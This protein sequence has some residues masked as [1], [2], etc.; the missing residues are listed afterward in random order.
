M[1]ILRY[2][3]KEFLRQYHGKNLEEFKKF[4]NENDYKIEYSHADVDNIYNKEGDLV[5]KV[6]GEPT[7]FLVTIFSFSKM[8]ITHIRG[9]DSLQKRLED[10]D[11]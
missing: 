11:L 7:N 2:N 4:L 1:L 3:M 10:L 9:D 6:S 8:V 5:G